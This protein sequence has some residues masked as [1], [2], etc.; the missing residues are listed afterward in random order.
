MYKII[1]F[2][3]K[4][5]LKDKNLISK[6]LQKLSLNP[7]G[8]THLSIKKLIKPKENGTFRLRVGKYRIIYDVD[9]SNKIIIIYRVKQRKEGY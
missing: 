1:F 2:K 3:D 8:D 5:L 6:S 7:F 4:K 9:T